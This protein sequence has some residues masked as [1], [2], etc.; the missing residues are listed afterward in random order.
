MNAITPLDSLD[1]LLLAL[2]YSLRCALQAMKT[3]CL[4][5]IAYICN[6]QRLLEILFKVCRER[7]RELD[8][9]LFE[10]F[11]LKARTHAP[12]PISYANFPFF[13]NQFPH[14]DKLNTKTYIK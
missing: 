13:L 1:T 5:R 6:N 4:Y 11:F 7:E 12:A 9:R 14:F 10:L 8:S 3:P 2:L